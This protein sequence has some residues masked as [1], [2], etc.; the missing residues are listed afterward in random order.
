M[1]RK[2]ILELIAEYNA[3]EIVR[4]ELV[5][6]LEFLLH[7]VSPI[8]VNEYIANRLLAIFSDDSWSADSRRKA[9]YASVNLQ[10]LIKMMSP[11]TQVERV[12]YNIIYHNVRLIQAKEEAERKV[13]N[14]KR[15]LTFYKD[16]LQRYVTQEELSAF[17]VSNPSPQEPVEYG[18][19]PPPTELLPLYTVFLGDYRNVIGQFVK[20]VPTGEIGRV[21]SASDELGNLIVV[22]NCNNDWDNYTDYTGAKT[23]MYNIVFVSDPRTE[24][25]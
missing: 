17:E 22:Y 12:M 5:T 23:P 24:I 25:E 20:Y 6:L 18:D 21:K 14:Y 15:E 7:D 4:E 13:N 10:R 19:V 16:L 9:V 1:T 8:P 3:P 11:K 2:K